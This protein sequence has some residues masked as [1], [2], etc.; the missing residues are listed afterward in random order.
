MFGLWNLGNCNTIFQVKNMNVLYDSLSQITFTSQ[1]I[2]KSF[3]VSTSPKTQFMYCYFFYFLILEQHYL[4]LIWH[5]S[6]LSHV[7]RF[8]FSRNWTMRMD[9][10]AEAH[11]GFTLDLAVHKHYWV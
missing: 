6:N 11:C 1:I 3:S 10:R 5:K 9:G 4:T 7:S 8:S 2:S